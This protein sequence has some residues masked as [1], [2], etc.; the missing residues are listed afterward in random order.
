MDVYRKAIES[1]YS[2]L[3]A[4]TEYAAAEGDTN[5][6]EPVV[7]AENI[8]CRL[9][10]RSAPHTSQTETGN[11]L[12]QSVKLF[13]SPDIEVKPGS[14][15]AVTQNGQS[16]TYQCAG[17]PAVYPSHQEVELVLARGWA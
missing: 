4:I 7:A 11:G 13:L 9:S 2:G 17:Q 3:C 5:N 16:N 6:P 10:F 1:R 14:Q 15:I 12:A 8:P